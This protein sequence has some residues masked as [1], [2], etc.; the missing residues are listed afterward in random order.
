MK[1]RRLTVLLGLALVALLAGG[2]A[3]AR[4]WPQPPGEAGQKADL[5]HEGMTFAEVT[6]ALEPATAT[7]TWPGSPG[8]G[9]GYI[10][11]GWSCDDESVL[12]VSFGSPEVGPLRVVAV[13]TTP[14]VSL[15]ARLR[16]ELE[17]LILLLAG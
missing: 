3:A 13:R 17:E 10:E 1:R 6:K 15:L 14:P 5:I 9:P 11:F 7:P 8:S 16:R 12:Y 4:L 2:V